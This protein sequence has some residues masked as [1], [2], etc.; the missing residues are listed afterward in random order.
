VRTQELIL[1]SRVAEYRQ[2]MA[3]MAH[4]VARKQADRAASAATA[5]KLGTTLPMVEQRLKMKEELAQEGYVSRM[6]LIESKLEYENQKNDLV[7]QR[8]R[9]KEAKAAMEMAVETRNQAEAE[10]KAKTLGELAEANKR[11]QSV[12]QELVKAEQR[13]QQQTL[14]APVDGIVQ[15]LAIHTVGGVATAAQPLLTV[16]PNGTSYEIEAQVLNKDI[17]F[18]RPEQAVAVK[19]DAFEYTKYGYLNGRIQ[20]V[21]TDAIQDQKLGL[22]YPVRVLVAGNQLPSEVNGKRPSIGAG[23]S[24]TADI[25]VAKRRAYEYFLGPLLRYKTESLRER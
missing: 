16:V 8:A 20:W 2:K 7:A 14:V 17:G 9:L 18:L 24:V 21:G 4:E 3:A 1:Q 12:S 6:A 10:F 15:Q 11:W 19:L 13:K 25:S 5:E 23:M 22:V